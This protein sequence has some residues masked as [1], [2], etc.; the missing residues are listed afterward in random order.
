MEKLVDYTDYLSIVYDKGA[1]QVFRELARE[2]ISQLFVGGTAPPAPVL[3]QIQPARY[4]SLKFIVDS[5]E[6]VKS[7]AK[8]PTETY[9]GTIRYT[10]QILG[11]TASDTLQLDSSSREIEMVLQMGYK[12]FGDKSLLVWEVLLKDG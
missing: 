6:I 12:D 5:V 10:M 3:P 1:E 2:N 8:E 11:I 9:R 4:H 7:L